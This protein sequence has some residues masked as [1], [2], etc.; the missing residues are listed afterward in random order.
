MF[1]REQ[2]LLNGGPSMFPGWRPSIDTLLGLDFVVVTCIKH[3]KV[4]SGWVKDEEPSHDGFVFVDTAGDAWHINYPHAD[5]SQTGTTNHIL[6]P[7]LIEQT[8]VSDKIASKLPT[9][10]SATICESRRFVEI[11]SYISDIRRGLGHTR[12]GTAVI[13]DALPAEM[14]TA[15]EKHLAWLI[16]T[17]KSVGVHIE[18]IDEQCGNPDSPLII[19]SSKIVIGD[20]ARS[21]TVLAV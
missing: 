11:G 12:R 19:G 21:T 3:E 7:T 13:G 18:L 16:E 1:V 8:A 4:V 2:F 5:V 9:H 14:H 17:A 6:K 15:L 20:D 10:R